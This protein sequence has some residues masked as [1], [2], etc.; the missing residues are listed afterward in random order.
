[1]RPRRGLV[2]RVPDGGRGAHDKQPPQ[3]SISLL[4]DTAQPR[5]AAG[6][7]LLRRQAEPG[8]ELPA[9]AELIGIGDGGGDRG[10]R[11]HADPRGICDP[12]GGRM[13]GVPWA[14]WRSSSEIFCPSVTILRSMIS[15]ATQAKE[16]SA[17]RSAS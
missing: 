9:G 11:D 7:L 5:L 2:L 14:I 13:I 4:R 16:A 17:S 10:G 3:I 12:S 15:R 6:R 8:G 1:M